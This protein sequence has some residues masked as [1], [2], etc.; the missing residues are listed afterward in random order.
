MGKDW[1]DYQAEIYSARLKWDFAVLT[2]IKSIREV[3][4]ESADHLVILYMQRDIFLRHEFL[5]RNW[6]ISS[7]LLVENHKTPFV[8]K[9]DYAIP[10]DALSVI[11]EMNEI[12]FLSEDIASLF[13]LHK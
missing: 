6:K 5:I 1:Y 12:D 13:R 4:L 10:D 9:F 8:C 3:W 11:L 2:N 7:F